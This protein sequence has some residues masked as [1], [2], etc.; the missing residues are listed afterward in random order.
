MRLIALILM[1]ISSYAYCK[2]IVVAVIDTGFGHTFQS[3]SEENHLCKYGH[4]DF[5]SQNIWTD[6]VFWVNNKTRDARKVKINTVDRVP[7]DDYGHGTNI[8]GL[9]DQNAGNT[10]Y[11]IVI[12][13]AFSKSSTD[14]ENIQN[15][16]KA[17]E[18]VNKLKPDIVN[19]SAAGYYFDTLESQGIKKYLDNGGIFVAAAGNK[20]IELSQQTPYYPAMYDSRIV[21]VGNKNEDGTRQLNSNYGM[22]VNDWEVGV[23]K[24]AFGITLTGTSH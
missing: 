10:N 24:T 8:V 19:Y 21:V 18:Y 12:I 16:V 11:C 17:I 15:S 5:T 2:P 22:L 3:V 4:K 23:D 7:L 6:D 1:T 14:D 13:K 9:I 20:N